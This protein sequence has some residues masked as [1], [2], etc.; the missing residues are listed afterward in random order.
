ML[1]AVGLGSIGLLTMTL[2]SNLLGSIREIALLSPRGQTYGDGPNDFPINKTSELVGITPEQIGDSWRLELTGGSSDVT[3]SRADLLAMT[4]Y[5]RAPADRLRRGL[6]DLA[7]LDAASGSRTWRS[8]PASIPTA[9]AEVLVES[10]QEGGA[11]APGDPRLQPDLRRRLA[12]RA[13]GQRRR[14]L[15]PTTAT[16]RGSSS[17]PCPASTTRSGSSG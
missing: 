15:R 17:P 13:A 7:G 6:D 9:T 14:P 8:W 4:Q 16:P 1:G 10:L 5:E 2:G 3:L 11:F 12:A